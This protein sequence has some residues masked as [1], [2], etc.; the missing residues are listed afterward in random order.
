MPVTCTFKLLAA[1]LLVALFAACA[2]L[3]IKFTTVTGAYTLQEGS[4]KIKSPPQDLLGAESASRFVDDLKTRVLSSGVD[5]QPELESSEV[6]LVVSQTATVAP[7]EVPYQHKHSVYKRA[8]RYG[9]LPALRGDMRPDSE[10]WDN[11]IAICACMFGENTTDIREW[12][13]Y[14]KCVL[15]FLPVC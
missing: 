5:R 2:I 12:I 6:T 14:N 8:H 4:E 3:G 1:Q 15:G 7:F 10:E 9:D 11:S 13:M